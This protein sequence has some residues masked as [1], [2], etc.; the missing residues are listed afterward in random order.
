MFRPA[1]T[2]IGL[3]MA[4]MSLPAVTAQPTCDGISLRVQSSIF[5]NPSFEDMLSCPQFFTDF[6][7]ILDYLNPNQATPDVYH[8]CNPDQFGLSNRPYPP[9][10]FPDGDVV[11]GFWNFYEN[12]WN[13]GRWLEYTGSCLPEDLKEGVT[14]HLRFHVGF[15]EDTGWG[16]PESIQLCLFGNPSSCAIPYAGQD[17]PPANLGWEPIVCKVVSGKNEWVEYSVEF[18]PNKDYS[19]IIIGPSCRPQQEQGYFFLDAIFL[20]ETVVENISPAV[21]IEGA[22]C[23]SALTLNA[24]PVSNI[25]E[26]Q[27]FYNGTPI[28]GA[29]DI[30]YTLPSGQEG[31]YWVRLTHPQGDGCIESPVFNL[32]L[33]VLMSTI[34][35]MICEGQ[36]IE[37]GGDLFDKTGIYDIWLLNN[38]GC[39]S[40]VTLNLNV[41]PYLNL[42]IMVDPILCSGDSTF[43]LITVIN[44][45]GPYSI[46]WEDGFTGFERYLPAGNYSA[47]VTA[48]NGCVS[49][50]IVSVNQPDILS[51][52]VFPTN[53]L[54]HS[55][56]NG[57]IEVVTTGGTAPYTI[58]LNNFPT[59]INGTLNQANLAPGIYTIQIT[60]ENLCFFSQEVEISEPEPSNLSIVLNTD[61]PIIVKPISCSIETNW[62]IH[63]VQ[64]FWNLSPEGELSCN[65]CPLLEITPTHYGPLHIEFTGI[66]QNNCEYYTDTIL[67]IHHGVYIPNVFSPNGD[68]ANDWFYIPHHGQIETIEMLQIFNRWGSLVYENVNSAA[69][70]A[71]EGW[72]GTFKGKIQNSAVFVYQTRIRLIDGTTLHLYGDVLLL[73]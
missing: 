26:Y 56:E 27:W 45:G 28:N 14:Y 1:L 15:G 48:E 42:D 62:P 71:E 63:F 35:T 33:P 17:C 51:A 68:G 24:S 7:L 69:G 30:S 43:V 49:P 16:T 36:S 8:Q 20:Q 66:D 31:E 18:T 55:E 52:E 40:L 59:T 34:D 70:I 4:L 61:Q 23:E 3:A 2:C 21:S 65:N 25:Y 37:I 13:G 50:V 72:N 32:D 22:Y 41:F 9:L 10:P 29:N 47:M 54:C 57:S 46:L 44:N 5:P 58:Q 6:H 11:L 64:M 12:P 38:W 53:V 60:D 39:D 67:Q 19:T 73:R